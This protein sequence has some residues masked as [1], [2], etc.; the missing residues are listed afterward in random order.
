MGL[1]C[2]ISTP[3]HIIKIMVHYMDSNSYNK[4]HATF[5]GLLILEFPKRTASVRRRGAG[6]GFAASARKA[7]A[8]AELQKGSL[9]P[10]LQIVDP[11][12]YIYIYI[13]VYVYTHM[14]EYGAYTYYIYIYRYIRVFSLYIYMRVFA[15]VYIYIH[16]YMCIYIYIYTRT[17]IFLM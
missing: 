15:C 12:M 17:C 10:R 16:M 13:F 5:L 11:I 1:L 9:A 2:I 3:I 8:S 6:S 4:A 14:C 7:S